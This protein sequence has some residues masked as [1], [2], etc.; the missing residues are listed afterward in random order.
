MDNYEPLTFSFDKRGGEPLGRLVDVSRRVHDQS[1]RIEDRL[2][3]FD[4][5]SDESEEAVEIFARY[6]SRIL[7]LL[8]DEIVLK[9]IETDRMFPRTN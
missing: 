5:V 8:V 7:V 1:Y 2:D 3:Y 6:F 4:G 9:R